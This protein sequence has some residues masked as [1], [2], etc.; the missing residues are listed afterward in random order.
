MMRSSRVRVNLDNDE[1]L[2]HWGL[3]HHGEKKEAELQHGGRWAV[4][5]F[6]FLQLLLATDHQTKTG[7]SS[8]AAQPD[9]AP[10]AIVG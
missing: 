6:R 5:Q 4:F 10:S 9:R 7:N 2:A 1:I 8:W 3:L